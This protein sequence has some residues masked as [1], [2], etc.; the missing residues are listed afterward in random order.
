MF[1]NILTGFLLTC[2]SLLPLRSQDAKWLQAHYTKEEISVPMRDGVKLFTSIYVPKGFHRRLPIL[3]NRT[4]YSIAPY[5]PG[6]FPSHLGPSESF[7]KEGFIFVYQDVRG[8]FM[9]GGNFVDMTPHKPVKSGPGDVDESSDTFDTIQ[10]LLNH[11]KSNGRVGQWGISYPGFYAAAGMIDAHPAL[12]AVSPQA[13]VMDWFAG[14]DFHRNGALWLPHLFNF[15][16]NFG[17]PRPEPTTE[18]PEAFQ[19]GTEDGFAFFLKMGPL[20]NANKLYFHDQIPFW[21]EVMA[22][23]SYDAFWKSRNLRPHLQKIRP[24]VLV[25]GGWFDAENLYGSLQLHGAL[26]RQSPG[27]EEHLVMGPWYHG[28]WERDPGE[29]LG[30]VGFEAATSEFFLQRVELPFFLHHLKRGPNPKLPK[31][32]VFETGQN[33]WESFEAW[34]PQSDPLRV[35]FQPGGALGPQAPKVA[36]GFDGYLS[37]PANPVPFYP[38]KD[39]GMP[40]EYMVADQRFVSTRPDVLTY[41]SSVLDSDLSV[42]GPIRVHLVVST[43]G[44]DADWVVKVIDAYPDDTAAPGASPGAQLLIRGEV[45]RGKFRNGLEHPEPFTPGQPTVVEFSLNDVCHAFRKGHR[46]MVQVQSSWFPLMDRN[47]QVFRDIYSSADADFHSSTHQVYR[48]ASQAS[49]LELPVIKTDPSKALR[50]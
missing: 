21:N 43:S 18:W 4:P 12:V 40:R 35:Y 15:I 1:T 10:W 6:A 39:I 13:P 19:H 50:H 32:L 36:E 22:H 31:A 33:R 34:P 38:G 7:A 20:P 3:L 46:L 24:V 27:T 25:V 26:Q 30:D 44:T 49:Y 5:G 37:D 8:R 41:Q 14:D 45:M 16:A 11:V 42:A 47:P 48:N 23:G 28:A 2:C 17:R 29:A 9:S